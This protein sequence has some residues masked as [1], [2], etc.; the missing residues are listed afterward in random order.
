VHRRAFLGTMAG[1]L[2]AAPLAAE[3]QPAGN[4]WRIGYLSSQSAASVG[5]VSFDAFRQGLRDLGYVEGQNIVIES[6]WANGEYERLPTLAKELVSLSPDLIVSGGG[7]PTVRAVKAATTTVP[8]VFV[9][10]SAVAAGI[11]SN[12]ARPTGNLTGFDLL[13]EELYTKQLALLKETLPKALR[14]AVLWNTRI[15]GGEVRRK[16]LEIA[17]QALRVKLRFLEAQHPGEIDTALAAIA[18]ERSDALFV[19]SDPMFASEAGRI[20]RWTAG[21]RLPTM[22]SWRIFP[23]GGGLISYSTD[24]AAVYRR[25]AIYVDKILRGAKPADL[26]VEQPTKYELVINLKTAKAL[27]LTIPQSLLLRADE[28]IQ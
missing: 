13:E 3:A 9:T 6:R 28:V 1:G 14:V 2:L 7:D 10:G 8:V 5:R 23:E 19:T 17:A 21:A 25:A 20:I 15:A 22:Y 27:G 26:P 12:L 24:L 11:V 18:R 16:G 4:V